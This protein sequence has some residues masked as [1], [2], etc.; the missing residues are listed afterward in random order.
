MQARWPIWKIVAAYFVMALLAAGSVWF[1][2][3]KVHVL[4]RAR[5][6]PM[7]TSPIRK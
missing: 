2:D 7:P 5:P 3:R 4:P 6:I 1:V